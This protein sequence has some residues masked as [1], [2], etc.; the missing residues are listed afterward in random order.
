LYR[1]GAPYNPFAHV[2]TGCKVVDVRRA[3][4]KNDSLDVELCRWPLKTN[5]VPFSRIEPQETSSSSVCG[6]IFLEI[7]FLSH[8]PA[9]GLTFRQHDHQA[10]VSFCRLPDSPTHL[11]FLLCL[12]LLSPSSIDGVI[13]GASLKGT[14]N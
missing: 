9:Q 1:S 11:P 13:E 7:S 6:S 5:C 3:K 14:M 8:D 4:G 12:F 2:P 10:F